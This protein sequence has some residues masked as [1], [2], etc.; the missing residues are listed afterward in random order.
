MPE[1]WE[2]HVDEDGGLVVAITMRVGPEP[3][4]EAEQRLAEWTVM[5]VISCVS[6][7]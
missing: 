3:S 4:I 7:V 6:G 2:E 5:T 1:E